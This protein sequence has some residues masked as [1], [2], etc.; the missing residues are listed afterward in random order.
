MSH[1]LVISYN[2]LSAAEV[3]GFLVYMQHHYRRTTTVNGMKQKWK[4]KQSE[5]KQNK[6]FEMRFHGVFSLLCSNPVKSRTRA[7]YAS[8][9]DSSNLIVVVVR[10]FVA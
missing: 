5:R 3:K 1:A 8:L 10:S 4:R 2:F 6:P 7:I 9:K